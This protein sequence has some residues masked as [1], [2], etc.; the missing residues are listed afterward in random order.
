[1]RQI[2]SPQIR[3]LISVAVLRRIE[4]N[5]ERRKKYSLSR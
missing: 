2:T 1:V 5:E 4:S 3:M